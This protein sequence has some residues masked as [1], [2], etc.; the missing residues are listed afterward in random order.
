MM[1]ADDVHLTNAD[2]LDKAFVNWKLDPTKPIFK[3]DN[4]ID[5]IKAAIIDKINKTKEEPNID[6]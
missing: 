2:Y 4:T 5:N 1:A 3:L 6:K